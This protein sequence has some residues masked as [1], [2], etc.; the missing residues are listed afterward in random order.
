M[1]EFLN[2]KSML[3]PGVAGALSV[4]ITGSLVSQFGLPGSWTAL[5]ISFLIGT[6]V[7]LNQQ[8]PILQRI[9]FYVLNSLVIFSVAVGVNEAGRA[10]SR[11]PVAVEQSRGSPDTAGPPEG[12][13]QP[14]F[15]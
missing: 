4:M 9:L 7:W 8:V 12:F 15:R 2:P 1:D 5:V 6:I 11:E 14:W 3:T 10:V 13:F